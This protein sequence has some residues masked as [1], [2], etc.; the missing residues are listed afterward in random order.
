M[1][2]PTAMAGRFRGDDVVDGSAVPR[3]ELGLE[4]VECRPTADRLYYRA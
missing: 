1:D 3:V 4:T 2:G